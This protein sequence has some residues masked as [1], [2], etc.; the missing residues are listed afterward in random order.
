MKVEETRLLDILYQVYASALPAEKGRTLIE[1]NAEYFGH[2][3]PSPKKQTKF[4]Q[5]CAEEFVDMSPKKIHAAMIDAIKTWLKKQ[6]KV[7]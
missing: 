6:P 3:V 5:R 2:V 1:I 7:A 4:L